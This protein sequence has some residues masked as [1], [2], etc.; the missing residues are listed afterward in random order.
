ME[1]AIIILAAGQS[2]RMRGLD[3]LTQKI[4]GLPQIQRIALLTCQVSKKVIVALPD[5]AHPRSICL[6][7]LPIERRFIL[8]SQSGMGYSLAS[9][10]NTLIESMHSGVMIIPADMPDLTLDDIERLVTAHH[11]NPDLIAQAISANERVGHPV[12]FPSRCFRSLTKLA[13]DKGARSLIARDRK[14]IKYI[15]LPNLHA[16]N[17]LDTPEDWIEWR[18]I[19]EPD[20]N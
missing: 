17:D 10:A 16:I 9:A 1:I 6:L 4:S 3:K 13:G 14:P 7:G 12:V 18:Y 8:N 15:A 11:K 2:K 19:S 5:A 20:S